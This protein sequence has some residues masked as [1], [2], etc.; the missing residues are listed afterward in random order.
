MPI[1]AA[2][3][4][5]GK[6]A[7]SE[8][9]SGAGAAI[10]DAAFSAAAR[11]VCAAHANAPNVVGSL[12][13]HAAAFVDGACRPYYGQAGITGPQFSGGFS[14][15]Q[16]P[17]DYNISVSVSN[18]LNTS[19]QL[20]SNGGSQTRVRGPLSNPRKVR[21]G[22]RICNGITYNVFQ[23]LVTLGNGTSVAMATSSGGFSIAET[24]QS[25][26]KWSVTT[27]DGSPDNCGNPTGTYQ[28]GI[29]QPN[30]RYGDTFNVDASIEGPTVSIS[31]GSPSLNIDGS[32]N[33]PVDIG[34]VS[35]NFGYGDGGGAGYTPPTTV[36]APP[37]S[38]SAPPEGVDPRDVGEDDL[39]HAPNGFKYVGA[40]VEF[41]QFPSNIGVIVGSLPN[42]VFPRTVGNFRLKLRSESVG[43]FLSERYDIRED[44]FSRVIDVNGL[45][46]V[47]WKLNTEPGFVA[48]V[49][50]ILRKE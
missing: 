44:A 42:Q 25:E 48:R 17:K 5:A 13:R 8:A 10:G 23:Y 12:G 28:P 1:P 9:A 14:G 29:G 11:G 46:C 6:L 24:P 21:V 43:V 40:V 7:L 26:V 41:T 36:A 16:C 35:V 39:P 49:T 27:W 50:P 30:I 45:R 4:A 15:G 19:C 3:I 38:E 22:S 33:I 18:S 34:G 47:G 32:L 31:I 2:L 20:G 37:I